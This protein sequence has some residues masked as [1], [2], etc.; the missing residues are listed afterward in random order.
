MIRRALPAAPERS[1][2]PAEAAPV[3]D[4]LRRW[5][6]LLPALRAQHDLLEAATARAPFRNPGRTCVS[7]RAR[8][9]W[10]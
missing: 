8:P 7:A 3:A 9:A 4:G 10:P 2:L 6:E 1:A 5:R